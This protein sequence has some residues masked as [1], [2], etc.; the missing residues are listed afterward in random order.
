M[1]RAYETKAERIQIRI[2]SG[3]KRKLQRAAALAS[4]SVSAFV[5][6]GAL[7]AAGRLIR[8]HEQIVLG[9]R[10]W[11]VFFDALVN[12]PKPKPALK[13]AFALHGRLIARTVGE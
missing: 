10:V 5:V 6:N 8:E 2:D 13:K 9:E 1:A 3:A 11:D 4:T 12:P 7:E